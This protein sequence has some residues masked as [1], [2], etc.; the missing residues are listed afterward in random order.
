MRHSPDGVR[1]NRV[2]D[3][4]GAILQDQSRR[5]LG[6][7]GAEALEV[8]ADVAAHVDEHR[9]LRPVHDIRGDEAVV[10]E[11]VEPAGLMGHD[12]AHDGVE[13]AALARVGLVVVEE[14]AA[15]GVGG[16]LEDAVLGVCGGGVAVV[17]EEGGQVLEAGEGGVVA[18]W[19]LV[20]GV[21]VW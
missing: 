8:A 17:G 7:G 12:G 20:R 21:C 13:G 11:D 14:V 15:G 3:D 5:S 2:G 18:G 1:T 6:M 19:L 10:R 4:M 16:S 9:R